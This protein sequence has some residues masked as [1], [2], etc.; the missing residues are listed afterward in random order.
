VPFGVRTPLE[1][2][3]HAVRGGITIDLRDM[4]GGISVE[5]LDATVEAGVTRLQVNEALATPASAFRSILAPTTSCRVRLLCHAA[6]DHTRV[7]RGGSAARARA[8]GPV[9]PVAARQPC[10]LNRE[11]IASSQRP[12]IVP[13]AAA[14][15]RHR[16][17]VKVWVGAFGTFATRGV[18]A[19]LPTCEV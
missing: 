13:Y 11:A 14:P 18:T 5:D 2:H 6:S 4:V 8:S 17:R 1:G 7:D 12:A 10:R 3:V 16:F 15:R 19:E 9:T